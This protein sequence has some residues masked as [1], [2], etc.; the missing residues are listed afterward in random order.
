MAGF[1]NP[2]DVA[3]AILAPVLNLNHMMPDTFLRTSPT[4]PALPMSERATTAQ[5]PIADQLPLLTVWARN[6]DGRILQ[7]ETH[8]PPTGGFVRV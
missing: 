6:L 3:G 2:H 1:A 7:Q 5:E 8:P 4:A